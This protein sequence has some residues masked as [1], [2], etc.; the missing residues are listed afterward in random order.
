VLEHGVVERTAA[1]NA[2]GQ[3]SGQPRGF[4]FGAGGPEDGPGSPE[5]FDQ[6]RGPRRSEPG[7]QPQ[8]QPVKFFLAVQ[9]WRQRG[10]CSG[11]FHVRKLLHQNRW[12]ES[13]RNLTRASGRQP[14]AGMSCSGWSAG[15]GGRFCVP[16]DRVGLQWQ[17][18]PVRQV[19]S[20]QAE[21]NA[22]R[23]ILASVDFA[24][25]PI[26]PRAQWHEDHAIPAEWR[27]K[28]RRE[29]I[30]FVM[31]FGGNHGVGGY[32]QGC[33]PGNDQ[34][35]VSSRAAAM[36]QQRRQQ[37]QAGN[38]PADPTDPFDRRALHHK[39]ISNTGAWF[40]GRRAEENQ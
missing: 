10:G 4:Q 23:A 37:Q 27:T 19:E 38:S 2:L 15:T 33:T 7:N 32:R 1:G 18:L 21:E 35:A 20:G 24:H 39:I 11:V 6:T 8:S 36:D 25:H 14:G 40:G 17:H 5:P 31:G 30:P 9:G 29:G 34:A 16:G 26:D 3:I 12:R 13:R 22:G 28:R